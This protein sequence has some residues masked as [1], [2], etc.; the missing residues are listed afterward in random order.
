MKPLTLLIGAVIAVIVIQLLALLL[1]RIALKKREWPFY[2]RKLMSAPEQVLYFKLCRALPECIV[3]SQVGL[4]RILGVK[5]GNK[6][7]EW[8]NRI[9]RMS[10]DFVICAKDASVL[11]VIELD[12]KSHNRS[13]RRIADAK[14]DK[15][16][17]AAGI[18]IIRW[19][20]NNVPD[21]AGIK[22]TI[23]G[24]PVALAVDKPD[25]KV[26]AT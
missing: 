4:S 1:K 20:V 11:A 24:Q 25:D 23:L 3:L 18:K 10:A 6:F 26:S 14:K 9:N 8:N 17:A 12:D 7:H 21:E 13:D 22:Q 15:A 19:K 2:A 5:K 16:L